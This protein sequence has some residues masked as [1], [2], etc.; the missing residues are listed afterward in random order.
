VAK[1]APVARSPIVLAPP[2]AVVGAWMVPL[3]TSAASLRIIDCT[4]V[5]KV[6]IRAEPTAEAVSAI[7]VP[8]GRTQRSE[9]GYL[10]TGSGP[11]EWVLFGPP[12][13]APDLIRHAERLLPSAFVSVVDISHGRALVR[14]VGPN[15]TQVLAKVCA[16]DFSDAVTANGSALRSMVAHIVTDIVRDDQGGVNS[17][18][19]HCDRS[20]GQF[21][22]DALLDAGEEFGIDVDGFALPGI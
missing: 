19:L 18:L 10:I 17:Y 15:A 12:D 1:I 21:L 8:F 6:L 4:A 2:H 9:D 5:A 22:F 16:I 11:G 3:R 13:T 14:L 20:F 7:G